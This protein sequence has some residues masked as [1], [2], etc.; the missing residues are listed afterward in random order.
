[1]DIRYANAY[2]LQATVNSIRDSYIVKTNDDLQSL[3]ENFVLAAKCRTVK[4]PI[5]ASL[6]NGVRESSM[7]AATCWFT[8]PSKGCF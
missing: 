7:N 5:I 4:I 6:L 3:V 2:D 8:S 1:M